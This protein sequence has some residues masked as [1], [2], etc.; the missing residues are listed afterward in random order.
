MTKGVL[1]EQI[2]LSH[3]A[4]D[5]PEHH[6]SIIRNLVLAIAAGT[7]VLTAGLAVLNLA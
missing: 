3:G 5:F 6:V 4:D 1:G 7:V 2:W